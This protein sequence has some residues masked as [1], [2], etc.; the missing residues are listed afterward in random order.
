MKKFHI[1]FRT[2]RRAALMA[3]A[4]GALLAMLLGWMFAAAA[5]AG[6]LVVVG[7]VVFYLIYWRCPHCEAMLPP[8]EGSIVYCPY[9][10]K[11]LDQ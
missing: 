7:S 11:K 1:P 2:A 9:C 5:V 6:M 8:R 3:M 10:G 4:A